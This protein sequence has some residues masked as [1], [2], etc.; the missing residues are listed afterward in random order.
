MRRRIAKALH[1][2]AK[3]IHDEDARWAGVANL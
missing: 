3:R 2:L 1:L